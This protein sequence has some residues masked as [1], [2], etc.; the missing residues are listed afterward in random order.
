MNKE[1]QKIRDEF[2]N[3]ACRYLF[4]EQANCQ[5]FRQFGF[6]MP[7]LRAIPIAGHCRQR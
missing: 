7:A 1:I 3:Q 6:A 2:L 5:D 4:G